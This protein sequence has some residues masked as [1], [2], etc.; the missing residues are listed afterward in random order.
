[1]KLELLPLNGKY[2]GTKIE[3]FDDD[4]KSVGYFEIWLS[5][6]TEADWRCSERELVQA[7]ESMEM[8]TETDE[9]VE[10][11]WIGDSH[12]E[13]ALTYRVAKQIVG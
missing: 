8:P 1:M 10:R 3:V 7:R 9:E 12:Y 6:N 2:Y 5:P 4:G 11:E 13:C